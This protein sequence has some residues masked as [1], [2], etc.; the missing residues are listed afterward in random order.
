MQVPNFSDMPS[1]ALEAMEMAIIAELE[2][3]EMAY[4]DA[5]A[6]NTK[7]GDCEAWQ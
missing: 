4:Q 3:R 7:K 1:K 6:Y 2:S 5:L